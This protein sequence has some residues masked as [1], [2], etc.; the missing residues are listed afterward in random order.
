M[1]LRVDSLKKIACD[2]TIKGDG[3]GRQGIDGIHGL[4]LP[5]DVVVSKKGTQYN[6]SKQSYTLII[7]NFT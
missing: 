5:Q 3:V 1:A 2:G 4:V 6:L 7:Y